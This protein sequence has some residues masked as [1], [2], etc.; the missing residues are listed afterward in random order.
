MVLYM[1]IR[2]SR[3]DLQNQTKA[4]YKDRITTYVNRTRQRKLGN[5]FNRYT[6][7][8]IG[9]YIMDLYN[10]GNSDVDKRNHFVNFNIGVNKGKNRF[11]IGYGKKQ[12]GIFC[13]GG[14]CKYV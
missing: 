2:Y 1:Q 13:V 4:C 14:V 11:V 10:Y 6:I 8:Q 5:D 7:S 12:E 9:L 3:C